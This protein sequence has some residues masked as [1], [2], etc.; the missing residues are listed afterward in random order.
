MRALFLR[1]SIALLLG[2]ALVGPHLTRAQDSAID[3]GDTVEI[4]TDGVNMREDPGTDGEIITTLDIGIELE[5]I[6]GPEEADGYTWWM[7]V[8]LN[9]DSVDE[10]VSGWVV[11][12]FLAVDDG[13]P[14]DDDPTETPDPDETETPEPT[15]T[16]TPD[17]GDDDD[18]DVSFE[19]AGWVIVVDGPLNL[20]QNPGL[21]GDV[22]RA[23]GT[24]ETGTVVDPSELTDRD[25]Y[26]W[27]NITTED[28]ERGWAA[29]DFLDPLDEDPCPD[30]ECEP[31]EHEDLLGADAVVVIDGPV[32]LRTNPNLDGQIVDTIATGAVVN[33]AEQPQ[34]RSGDD[35]DWLRVDYQGDDVWVAVDFIEPSDATCDDESPC[36]PDTSTGDPFDDALGIRVVDGPLNVRDV[37]GLSGTIVDVLETGAEIPVDARAVLTDADGYTWIRI[38]TPA[39]NGWVATDFVEP[40]DE[41]PCT[42]GA[43]Y[44]A[45]LNPFFAATGAFVVDGPLNLRANPDTGADIEMVLLNGDYLWIVSVIDTDPYEADGYLW[46]EVNPAGTSLTGYVAI[47]FVE[48]AG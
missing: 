3:V 6:E 17:V 2:V 15:P 19:D 30:D 8:V 24:G 34:V 29:T 28:N 41:V 13:D 40:L 48:P 39:L 45:E 21:Q 35:Y 47:D 37:A 26:T 38:A 25:G 9:D 16:S 46:I 44:P 42:D 33:T 12:D 7:G 31:S 10:G 32:N 43:C 4:D 14:P 22:I 18:G 1:I 20:R 5:I 11:E 36:F 27:I 23:L